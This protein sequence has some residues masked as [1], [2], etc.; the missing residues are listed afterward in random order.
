MAIF[1]IT[2]A[3][4][5]IKITSFLIDI[6]INNKIKQKIIEFFKT[7]S[8]NTEIIFSECLNK[9]ENFAFDESKYLF[10]LLT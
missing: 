9:N 6:K 7:S 1:K 4:I 10:F 5:P 2:I 8:L 3:N